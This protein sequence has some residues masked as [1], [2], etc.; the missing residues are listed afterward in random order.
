MFGIWSGWEDVSAIPRSSRRLK[1]SKNSV[2]QLRWRD[3][4]IPTQYHDVRVV[5]PYLAIRCLKQLAHDK[6]HQFRW[7]SSVPQ[8]DFYVDVLTGADIKDEALSL[9]TELTELLKLAGWNIRKWT[10]N[11]QECLQ[12]LVIRTEHQTKTTVDYVMGNLPETRIIESLLFANVGVNYCGFF[13][14]QE[15]KDRNHL[16][17]KVYVAIC[18]LDSQ[19]GAYWVSQRPHEQSLQCRS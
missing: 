1:I 17:I 3:W 7:T 9:K 16:K 4:Y 8:R 13:Y 12:G 19:G 14:I 2:A 6:R 18:M 15:R 5:S 10:S 11:N